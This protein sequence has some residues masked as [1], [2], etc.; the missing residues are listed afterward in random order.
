MKTISRSGIAAMLLAVWCCPA[1]LVSAHQHDNAL[2]REA[3][4]EVFAWDP[5]TAEITSEKVA[6][7]LYV[8]FGLGGNIAVSIGSDGVLIVDDQIPELADKIQ[9]AIKGLGGERIDY[10]VNTH[11]HFDHADGNTASV[12]KARR[13][14][15]TATREKTWLRAASSTW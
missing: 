8:L 2:G 13:L 11:W 12:Q 6:D 10:I 9:S 7:G 1:T 4:L 5:K 3:L 15:P 14:W